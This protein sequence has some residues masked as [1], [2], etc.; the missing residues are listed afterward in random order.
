MMSARALDRVA[1]NPDSVLPALQA[2]LGREQ[3]ADV[4]GEIEA[5]IRRLRRR[6]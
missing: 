6:Q 1:E 5:A 2:R 4:R 3:E